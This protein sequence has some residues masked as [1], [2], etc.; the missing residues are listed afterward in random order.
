[1]SEDQITA[2]LMTESGGQLT[3]DLMRQFDVT[4]RLCAKLL[5]AVCAGATAA[6]NNS[7]NP[8]QPSSRSLDEVDLLANVCR[9]FLQ[10]ASPLTE[11]IRAIDSESFIHMND[12]VVTSK[13]TGKLFFSRFWHFCINLCNTDKQ[14]LFSILSSLCS[15][16][17]LMSPLSL[18]L[19]IHS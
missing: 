19:Q 18:R 17:C 8:Q 15:H 2:M 10:S 12:R 1:M 5:F 13:S 3:S 4:P 11:I 7:S 9:E 14:G 16:V 6:S